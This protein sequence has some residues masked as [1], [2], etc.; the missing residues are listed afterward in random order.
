VEIHSS[1]LVGD[2][3]EGDVAQLPVHRKTVAALDSRS[4]VF[5]PCDFIPQRPFGIAP[6]EILDFLAKFRRDLGRH[7]D[8]EFI[9]RCRAK[10]CEPFARKCPTN[11]DARH[12]SRGACR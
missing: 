9:A 2:I 6:E 5:S 3:E 10:A 7:R 11:R 1:D 8:S 12:G 4:W